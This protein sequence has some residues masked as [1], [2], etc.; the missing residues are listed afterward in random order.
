MCVR[1]AGVGGTDAWDLARIGGTG[2]T[3]LWCVH[4]FQFSSVLLDVGRKGPL[5]CDA[6]LVPGREGSR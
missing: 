2:Q 1:A 4:R 3:G 6:W 5:A